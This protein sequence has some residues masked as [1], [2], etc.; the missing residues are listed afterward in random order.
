MN[1]APDRDAS[2]LLDMLTAARDARGFLG[3]LDEAAFLASR[4][5]QNA[6]IRSLEVIGE[7]AGKVSAATQAAHP[8]VPWRD[9]TGM[10]HRLIHGY[11]DVRLEVV[12]FVVRERLDPLIQMLTPLVPDEDGGAE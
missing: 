7:A 6:V 8:D 10:R 11:A 3:G 1:E 4:L 12:W 2:L 9:I 5:H